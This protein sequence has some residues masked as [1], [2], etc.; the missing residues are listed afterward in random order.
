M[1]NI[2]IGRQ[3]IY[4]RNMQ[5]CAY[6]LLYREGETLTAPR[7]DG[8]Q[9]T[10]RVL[11]NT[12]TEIGLERI[13]G[14]KPAFVN[15]T[16]SFFID[17]PPIPFDKSRVVLE[18]LEDIKVDEQLIKVIKSLN[19]QRYCLALDDYRFEPKW[20]VILPCI[21]IIKVEV[22]VLNFDRIE[23]QLEK[24]RHY[25]L[26][27]LAEK[28]ENRKEFR[29]LHQL[30]FDYFQGYFFSRPQ[31]VSGARIGE[32]Q[33]VILRL[34]AR[35]NDP[36]VDIGELEKLLSM[37]PGLSYKILRFINSAAL[38][39]PRKIDSINQAVIYLGLQRIRAWASLIALSRIENKPQE[40]FNKSLIRAHMCARLVE[41][42]HPENR[43][44]AFTTGLLS[45]LDLLLDR[46]LTEILTEL[47]LS[48]EA[49]R[50]LL[51][52]TGVTGQALSCTLAYEENRWEQIEFPDLE[53]PKI[54]E[55]YLNS[56]EQAHT[57]QVALLEGH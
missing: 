49:K 20:D 33:L 30:G 31:I 50:V 3:A 34:L 27:L 25:N 17:Q 35:I 56:I 4:D 39:L 28:V 18:I 41:E 12:F 19:A 38:S 8:D 10:S 22:P 5:A 48:T 13:V 9:A 2:F 46:T 7:M 16:R 32:N 37:D 21:D 42:T 11:L 40:L 43:E 45:I 57:D 6:E 47:P 51:Q 23:N 53:L 15:L 52:H 24:L 29:H 36:E 1:H 26:K 55:I 54:Q 14:D 44:T